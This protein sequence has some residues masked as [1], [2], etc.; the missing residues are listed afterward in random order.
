MQKKQYS[1]E[2]TASD[3]KRQRHSLLAKS[4]H[5]P[6][7][8]GSSPKKSTKPKKSKGIKQSNSLR[9]SDSVKKKE[10]PIFTYKK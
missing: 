5:I 6:G 8:S 4:V 7:V 10:K 2:L 9:K 1:I 3:S